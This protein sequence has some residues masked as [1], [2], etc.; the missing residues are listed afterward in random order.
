MCQEPF[1][2]WETQQGTKEI[3]SLPENNKV[4]IQIPVS[5]GYLSHWAIIRIPQQELE[6]KPLEQGLAI[7]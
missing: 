3:K 1:K 4:G 2:V 7:E 6:V 5:L